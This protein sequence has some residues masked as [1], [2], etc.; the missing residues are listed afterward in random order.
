VSDVGKVNLDEK[1]TQKR[2]IDAEQPQGVKI[3]AEELS[4][5]VTEVRQALEDRQA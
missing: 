5:I 2:I 4:T 1:G 3:S